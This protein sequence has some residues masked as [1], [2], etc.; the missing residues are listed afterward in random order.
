[1]SVRLSVRMK[2][3]HFDW[4]DFHEILYLGIFGKSVE[5]SS[6]KIHQE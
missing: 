4:T 5:R 1:M 6:I 2:Q 3:L